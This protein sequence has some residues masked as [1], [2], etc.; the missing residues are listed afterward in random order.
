MERQGFKWAADR[1]AAAAGRW[2]TSAGAGAAGDPGGGGDL[3]AGFRCDVPCRNVDFQAQ[4]PLDQFP[5]APSSA[6]NVWGFV[7]LNDNREYAVIGLRNGTAVVEVTNPAKPREVGT[8]AGNTSAWR[9][10]K[11]YQ[12]RDNVRIVIAHTRTSRRKRQDSGMQVIDLSG[13]PNS[14]TLATTLNDTGSQHTLYVSNIDYGTN[15][16]LP[17]AEAFLYVA[18][19]NLN[20]GAWRVYSLANPAQP[21]L[22]ST[23]PAGTQYMHD[24]TSLLITDGRTTQCDQGHSPCQVLVDFNENTVDLWDVTNKNPPVRLSSTTY[25]SAAYTHSGWPSA[26]QRSCSSTTSSRRSSRGSTRRST[27]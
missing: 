9:E 14:V 21:Q 13:L 6:A 17:G 5:N 20:A 22:I 2:E 10:V 12:V 26:D 16:A 11:V 18:G 15:V 25:P 8:M 19:S 4:I 7:D 3:R 23:A 24:S 1:A 27:R